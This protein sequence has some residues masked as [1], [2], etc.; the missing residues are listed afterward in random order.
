MTVAVVAAAVF[1]VAGSGLVIYPSAPAHAA[2]MEEATHN[3]QHLT[4]LLYSVTAITTQCTNQ[5]NTGN[6]GIVDACSNIINSLDKHM[7]DAFSET[8]IDRNAVLE[9]LY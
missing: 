5:I 3:A 6:Y 1:L 8:E 2:D 9:T 4:G 7:S